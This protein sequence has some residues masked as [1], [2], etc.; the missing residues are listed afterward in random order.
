[1]SIFNALGAALYSKLQGTSGLTTLLAGTT[2]IYNQMAPDDASLDYVVFNV[3]AG[4]DDNTSAHRTKNLVVFVR[5]YSSA[6]AAK[7]GTIDAQIDTALHM[8]PLSISGWANFWLARERD[9][10]A[11]EVD[12]AK[13]K[14]WMRGG[15]YRVRAEKT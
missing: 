14:T 8:V 3:Q 10:E 12:A 15:Y 5:G 9:L 11:V 1:M 2:A 4:G 7:A 6:G 13:N